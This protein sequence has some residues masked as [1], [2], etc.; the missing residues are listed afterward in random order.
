MTHEC[1]RID[2][3]FKRKPLTLCIHHH[4]DTVEFYFYTMN[5][6]VPPS[7]PAYADVMKTSSSQEWFV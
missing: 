5:E 2:N 6:P 3:R 7:P 1:I 4:S